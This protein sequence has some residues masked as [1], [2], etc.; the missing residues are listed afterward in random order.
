MF[1]AKVYLL[2]LLV[3]IGSGTWPYLKLVIMLFMWFARRRPPAPLSSP[4]F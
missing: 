2:G 3:L 1:S 4:S